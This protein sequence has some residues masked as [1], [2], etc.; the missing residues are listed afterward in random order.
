M[1]YRAIAKTQ[2]VR[3]IHLSRHT[4]ALVCNLA[5]LRAC[6]WHSKDLILFPPGS[7]VMVLVVHMCAR[8]HNNT[9]SCRDISN[10]KKRLLYNKILYHFYYRFETPDPDQDYDTIHTRLAG[11]PSLGAAQHPGPHVSR[12]V[13]LPSL[14]RSLALSNLIQICPSPA[15]YSLPRLNRV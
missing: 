13:R 15:F 14:S 4:A 12:V 5:F 3:T 2:W 8:S 9:T 11:A 10:A 7:L 6:R 1:I